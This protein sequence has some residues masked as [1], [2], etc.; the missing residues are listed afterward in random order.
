MIVPVRN[1]EYVL[2]Y[3]LK[4]LNFKLFEVL[5]KM[6]SKGK[7]CYF[8]LKNFDSTRLLRRI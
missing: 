6:K 2:Q 3:H 4:S 7:N 1:E 8:G 5:T